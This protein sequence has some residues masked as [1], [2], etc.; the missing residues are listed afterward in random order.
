M[1]ATD[2]A[3]SETSSAAWTAF[4]RG[5]MIAA[6][7]RGIDS[8]SFQAFPAGIATYSAN[9]P[10]RSTPMTRSRSQMWKA[11]FRQE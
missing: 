8:S 4:P 1:T 2:F 7:S 11:P 9:A 10:S 5:S 6:T 3:A